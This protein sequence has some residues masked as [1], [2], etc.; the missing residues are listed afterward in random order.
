MFL[1]DIVVRIPAIFDRSSEIVFLKA[2]ASASSIDMVTSEW[3]G[4]DVLSR[5]GEMGDKQFSF[6]SGNGDVL[7]WMSSDKGSFANRCAR[8]FSYV[9]N[10]PDDGE[11]SFTIRG[12]SSEKIKRVLVRK[13]YALSNDRFWY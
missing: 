11:G 8:V 4:E 3:V 5:G 12:G 2:I 7:I 6:T 10:G 9:L 13:T 1:R